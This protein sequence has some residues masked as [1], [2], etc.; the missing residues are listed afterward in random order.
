M[1]LT[2]NLLARLF[3]KTVRSFSAFGPGRLLDTSN[4]GPERPR[5]GF[6]NGDF[7]QLITEFDLNLARSTSRKMFHNIG[8][9]RSAVLQRS[10]YSFGRDSWKPIFTGFDSK[11]G[12][13]ATDL[14]SAEVLPIIC[15]QGSNYD[16][17]TFLHTGS[18]ELDVSGDA[19]ILQTETDGGYPQLMMISSHRINSCE[20]TRGVV[21]HGA[22]RG[23]KISHGVITS[24]LGMPVAYRITDSA[25]PEGYIDVPAQNFILLFDPDSVDQP[26]GLP[27]GAHALVDLH[28]LRTVQDFEKLAAQL[29][30]CLALIEQNET[31]GSEDDLAARMA[32]VVLPNDTGNNPLP[33]GITANSYLGGLIKYFKSGSGGKI[34]AHHYDRPGES[35]IRFVNRMG[36]NYC[37]GLPWPFELADDPSALSGPNTRLITGQAMRSVDDRQSLFRPVAKRLLGWMVAKLQKIGRLPESPEWYKWDCTMPPLLSIDAGRDAVGDANDYKLGIQNLTGILREQGKELQPHL[38]ERAIECALRQQ[39]KAEIETRYNV[40]IPDAEMIQLTPNQAPVPDLAD[41]PAQPVS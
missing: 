7:S 27:S 34:E 28:D 40:E 18:I 24:Q 3:P 29:N 31:G 39:I 22:F 20:N 1:G 37:Q 9:M 36:R 35:Y 14:L 4:V 19:G 41:Q 5:I 32:N 17:T 25:S 12:D 11:W 23:A 8:I 21:S 26:R 6:F 13:Y 10:N 2:R 16:F 38:R 33:P 30:A 15:P